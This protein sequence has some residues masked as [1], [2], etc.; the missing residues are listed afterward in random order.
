MKY[1]ISGNSMKKLAGVYVES[2]IAD[3]IQYSVIIPRTFF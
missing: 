3:L 1:D 2:R